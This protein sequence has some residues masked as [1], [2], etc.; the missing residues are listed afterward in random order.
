MARYLLLL[1]LFRDCLHTHNNC[2]G[3][4]HLGFQIP[5]CIRCNKTHDH[6]AAMFVQKGECTKCSDVGVCECP[7]LELRDMQSGVTL[8]SSDAYNASCPFGYP[9]VLST[10]VTTD[11]G[12]T[13]IVEFTS[14][15]A[16]T[17]WIV[18]Y[19]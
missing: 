9:C 11:S 4:Y 16:G 5:F 19:S 1:A 14:N 15:P 2:I 7:K 13:F 8:F 17:D 10:T 18:T 6:S 12:C 3:C